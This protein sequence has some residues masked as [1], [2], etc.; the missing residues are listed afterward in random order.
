[1]DWDRGL[2]LAPITWPVPQAA[3]V[4]SRIMKVQHFVVGGLDVNVYEDPESHEGS[5][6]P[7][8]ALFILH[9]RLGDAD[10]VTFIAERAIRYAA[11]ASKPNK[12]GKDLIVVT[13]VRRTRLPYRQPALTEYTTG[14]SRITEIMESDSDPIL[15]ILDGKRRRVTIM[16]DMRKSRRSMC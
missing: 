10:S 9:G 7:V 13:F 15:G 6:R 16:K 8:A 4:V 5:R 1:M 11:E 2:L 14:V 12:A 3:P